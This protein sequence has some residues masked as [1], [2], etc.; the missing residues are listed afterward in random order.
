MQAINVYDIS[1]LM[2]LRIVQVGAAGRNLYRE[3]NLL[4]GQCWLSKLPPPMESCMACVMPG[5][6]NRRAIDGT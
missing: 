3:T 6:A 1:K 2:P 5:A 4:Y